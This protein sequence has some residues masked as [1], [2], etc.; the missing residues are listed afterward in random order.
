MTPEERRKLEKEYFGDPDNYYDG[1]PPYI[2]EMT[3][4]ELEEAITEHE[5]KLG[6]KPEKI[7]TV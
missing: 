3:K 2:N 1:T 6:I 7:E 4:E 5:E